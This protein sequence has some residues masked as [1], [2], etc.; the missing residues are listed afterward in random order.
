MSLKNVI[1]FVRYIKKIKHC[2]KNIF[3]E[4]NNF[5]LEITIKKFTNTA[6]PNTQ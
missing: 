4:L 3:N 5:R 6:Y 1:R 2:N